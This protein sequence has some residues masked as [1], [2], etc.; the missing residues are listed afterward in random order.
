MILHWRESHLY[1]AQRAALQRFGF[2]VIADVVTANEPI[3]LTDAY[4]HLRILHDSN[5]SDDDAWLEAVGIPA[6]REYCEGELGRSLATRTVEIATNKFPTVTVNTSDGPCIDL[7]FGPVQSVTSVTYLRYQTDSN[8]DRVLDSNGDAVTETA[9]VATSTYTIDSYSTPNRLLLAFGKSWPTDAIDTANS[10]KVRYVTGYVPTADSNERAVLPR[11]VRIAMLLM[12][13][14]L[15]ENREASGPNTLTAIPHGV[16]AQL[17]LVPD[18][19]R[20][21]MA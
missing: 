21:G 8:G 13:G 4:D 9:T 12:L 6:A 10:V 15:Y 14:H 2:K 18:R 7:P 5:G 17:E 16:Q 11:A 20:L 19:E 1:H 3:Q